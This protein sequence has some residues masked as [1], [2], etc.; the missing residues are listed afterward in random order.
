MIAIVKEDAKRDASIKKFK[1]S[2]SGNK[3]VKLTVKVNI[4][5]GKDSDSVLYASA[6]IDFTK[7]KPVVSSIKY[8]KNAFDKFTVNTTPPAVTEAPKPTEATT[9]RMNLLTLQLLKSIH[10]PH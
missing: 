5:G 9:P 2:F 4:A 3:K 6:E 8:E 10:K 1:V 7:E